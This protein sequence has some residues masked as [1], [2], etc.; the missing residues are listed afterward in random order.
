[1]RAMVGDG[2]HRNHAGAARPGS[3]AVTAARATAGGLVDRFRGSRVA[4]GSGAG[5]IWAV[6]LLIFVISWILVGNEF[7]S[8]SSLTNMA[9][10]SVAL[11][12]V[13]VGQT[14]ALLAGSI[15][16]SVAHTVSAG[17]VTAS[18]I[19]QGQPGRIVPGVLAVLAVGALIGL[20]NGLVITKLRLNAFIATLGTFLIVRGALNAS[21]TNW[22]G[23]VPR[24]F[25]A[26]GYGSLAKIP[27]SV[28]LL[29]AV[30]AGAWWLLR[31]TRVGYHLYATGGSEET[32]RL[33]GVRTHGT[34]ILTHV[35][36]SL[37]AVLA[38]LYLASRLR[39]GA[40]WVGPDGGYDLD[41]IAAAVV[42]GT[43]LAGGRGS[44]MGTV[45]G[46]LILAVLDTVFNAFEVDAFIKTL[47]RGLI[48]I[49]AVALYAARAP[50]GETA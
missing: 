35:L 5:P 39:S 21:F 41:S 8:P 16:L 40:P 4:T 2:S 3:P 7:V 38:G 14:L 24:E 17:A 32:A 29:A 27:F 49:G 9:V 36:C 28:F 20:L 19:M 18:F 22:T 48:I 45:A 37:C 47:L 26:L 15:D 50:K 1:M 25:Q 34:L 42:G 46:V 44:V 30:V 11:G 10:R 12:L 23:A 6:L 31:R 43:A 13:A 33:S